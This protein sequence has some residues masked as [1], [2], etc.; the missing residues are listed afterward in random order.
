M[1]KQYRS[2]QLIV[3]GGLQN[4]T[5]GVGSGSTDAIFHD[6]QFQNQTSDPCTPGSPD[7]VQNAHITKVCGS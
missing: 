7:V 5:L 1:R 2:P 4:L 3:Y 6:G